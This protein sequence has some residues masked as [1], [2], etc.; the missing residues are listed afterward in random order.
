MSGPC[1][2]IRRL[3]TPW[4]GISG[5]A[6]VPDTCPS[7]LLLRLSHL[8]RNISCLFSL[9]FFLTAGTNFI[10]TPRESSGKLRFLDSASCSSASSAQ[11]GGRL[12]PPAST[13]AWVF[14]FEEMEVG[15]GK[16]RQTECWPLGIPRRGS[17]PELVFMGF[18]QLT[19]CLWPLLHNGFG[20]FESLIP[21]F[22]IFSFVL[23][24]IRTRQ[25]ETLEIPHI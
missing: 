19:L 21:Y 20:R 7:C 3:D 15:K 9:P 25:G 18:G 23:F 6:D 17:G 14:T 4:R 24:L 16:V 12:N 1:C 8:H 22:S 10:H 13:P 2:G 11:D 5:Q